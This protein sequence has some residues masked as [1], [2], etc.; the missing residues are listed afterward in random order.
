M[1]VACRWGRFPDMWDRCVVAEMIKALA[2]N[3]AQPII[4]DDG[5]FDY[6]MISDEMTTLYIGGPPQSPK[7][8]AMD[9]RPDIFPRD[10]LE[11]R[12]ARRLRRLKH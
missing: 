2:A 11:D 7:L 10:G 9:V 5:N 6:S 3:P 12:I 8:S 4:S 1:C